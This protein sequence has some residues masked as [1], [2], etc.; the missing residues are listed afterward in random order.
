MCE[1]TSQ[2]YTL[3]V[4]QHHNRAYFCACFVAQ[5]LLSLLTCRECFAEKLI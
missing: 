2:N 4:Q 3:Y 5:M 1:E